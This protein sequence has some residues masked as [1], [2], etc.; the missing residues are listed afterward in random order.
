MPFSEDLNTAQGQ[1]V[2]TWLNGNRTY[3]AADGK[4]ISEKYLREEKL[5]Q[6]E[7]GPH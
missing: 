5:T 2:T 7:L 6:L 4:I 3:S 1:G